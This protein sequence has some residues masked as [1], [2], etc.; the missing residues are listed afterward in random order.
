[1]DLKKFT[2]KIEPFFSL[3]YLLARLFLVAIFIAWMY[4]DWNRHQEKQME[5]M[6][7]HLLE[8]CLTD[9]WYEKMPSGIVPDITKPKSGPDVE[10][11]TVS[12]YNEYEELKK[13]KGPKFIPG[14][15]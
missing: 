15:S 14:R 1:M 7:Q 9:C 5:E 3:R 2:D 4:T 6:R 13:E 11:C 10:K 12:C 8:N